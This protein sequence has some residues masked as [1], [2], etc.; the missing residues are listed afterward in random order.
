MSIQLFFLSCEMNEKEQHAVYVTPVAVAEVVYSNR[1]DPH[2]SRAPAGTLT[3]TPLNQLIPSSR[4]GGSNNS[5]CSYASNENGQLRVESRPTCVMIVFMMPYPFFFMGCCYSVSSNV[6][7]DDVSQTL[8]I[9]SWPGF[10]QCLVKTKSHIE[11]SQ[12][13]NLALEE[14]CCQS[15][16]QMMYYPLIVLKDGTKLYIS[17]CGVLDY[18]PDG[19]QSKVLA[20]HH[21]LFGRNNPMYAPPSVAELIIR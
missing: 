20:L 6:M 2:S 17:D 5:A 3:P 16:R 9:E 10:M 18:S 14:T 13:G 4:E 21:F 7:F 19:V 1:T 12:V 11:Y 15:N 8:S